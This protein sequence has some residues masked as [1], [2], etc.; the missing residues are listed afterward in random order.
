M[1]TTDKK[2]GFYYFCPG[3]A[4][5]LP[6]ELGYALGPKGV[7]KSVMQ[8]GG[9]NDG[10]GG[11]VFYDDGVRQPTDWAKIDWRKMP[12]L[13]FYFGVDPSVALPGPDELVRDEIIAGY[14]I[15]LGDSDGPRWTIPLARCWPEGSQIPSSMGYGPD[16]AFVTKP[17][18]RYAPLCRKAERLFDTLAVEYGL[19]EK[20][21]D[22][23]L[24]EISGG[25][26]GFDLAVEILA[27][28]YRVS[29]AE[30]SMLEL[31]STDML[32]MII[33]CLVDLPQISV[34]A[35]K[36]MK[37]GQKKTD[38]S[39]ESDAADSTSDGEPD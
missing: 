38:S 34:E 29:A 14:P 36:R 37:L 10:G 3:A 15:A 39:T 11:A 24:V 23:E 33:G 27:V 25:K 20:P 35:E 28:N 8:R 9:P 1:T 32:H 21:D 12:G 30:V 17:V 31:V 18:A 4:G 13:P 7:A 16:G 6:N 5:L 19:V 2:I 26:E 22:A